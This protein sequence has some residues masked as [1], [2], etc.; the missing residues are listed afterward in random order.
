M[1]R[2]SKE[3][4]LRWLEQ[5]QADL[6]GAQVLFDNQVYHLTCFIAQQT[7]E[8][9]V[10]AFLYARGEEMVT[11]HSVTALTTWAEQFDSDFAELRNEIA[12]LDGYYIPTRYP[13]GIPDSIPARVYTK[14]PAEEALQ[15]AVKAIHFVRERL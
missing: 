6:H 13:N 11:G 14:K 2:S 8:K 7:A 1:K 9:A 12:I 10:K 3:E 4:G 5:A 15:L